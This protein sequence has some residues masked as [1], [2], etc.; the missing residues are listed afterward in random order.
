MHFKQAETKPGLPAVWW[1]AP[2]EH[3][4]RVLV[5]TDGSAQLLREPAGIEKPGQ[6]AIS[7]PFN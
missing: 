2:D 6:L 4:I 3:G 7:Q 1:R 5:L